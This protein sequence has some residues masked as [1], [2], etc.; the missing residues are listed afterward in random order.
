MART[1]PEIMENS[2]SPVVRLEASLV[3]LQST[4]PVKGFL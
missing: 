2:V 3:V 4:R 1:F